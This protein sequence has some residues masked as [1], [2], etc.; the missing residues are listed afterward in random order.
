MLYIRQCRMNLTPTPPP[1][2]VPMP[3]LP[4]LDLASYGL[5]PSKPF[6]P[7]VLRAY[8]DTFMLVLAKHMAEEIETVKPEYFEKI[9]QEMM[10]D[11]D[12][13]TLKHIQHYDPAWFACGA[14]G[15]SYTQKS[16]TD[17]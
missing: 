12:A 2:P 7:A 5:D 10:K 6:L 15:M 8:M 4:D 13:K 11:A 17:D 3:E 14:I 1:S 9:G 16:P